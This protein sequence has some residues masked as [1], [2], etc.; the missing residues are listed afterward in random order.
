MILLFVAKTKY[1]FHIKDA[2]KK[3][4]CLTFDEV[5]DDDDQ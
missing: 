5:Q 2:S 1:L 4:F 3:Q